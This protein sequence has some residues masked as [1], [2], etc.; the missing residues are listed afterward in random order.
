MVKFGLMLDHNKAEKG[1]WASSD[2]CF[3]LFKVNAVRRA[4]RDKIHENNS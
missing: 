1:F 2:G 4:G 3:V